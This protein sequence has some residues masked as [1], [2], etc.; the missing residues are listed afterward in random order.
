MTF[1]QVV[2]GEAKVVKLTEQIA[3]LLLAEN[4]R[5]HIIRAIGCS[6]NKVLQLQVPKP[7]MLKVG[8]MLL[9]PVPLLAHSPADDP[10]CTRYPEKKNASATKYPDGQLV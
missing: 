2:H 4:R 6:V 7:L 8:Q 1:V 9:Q 5:K 10:I 3:Q